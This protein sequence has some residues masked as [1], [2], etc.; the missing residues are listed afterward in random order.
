[1][2]RVESHQSFPHVNKA[3]S[4]PDLH[5]IEMLSEKE[6]LNED[7]QKQRRS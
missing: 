3:L 6:T 5:V 4:N 1:M 7:N 2:V